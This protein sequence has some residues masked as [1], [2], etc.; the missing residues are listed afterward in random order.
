MT[1][2]SDTFRGS[3]PRLQFERANREKGNDTAPSRV[4]CQE[5]DWVERQISAKAQKQTEGNV[6]LQNTKVEYGSD[7]WTPVVLP[8]ME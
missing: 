2:Q 6:D 8:E 4:A 3:L 1:V 7:Q 5:P